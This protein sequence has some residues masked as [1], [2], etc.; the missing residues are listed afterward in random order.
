MSNAFDQIELN[1]RAP[2]GHRD[3]SNNHHGSSFNDFLRQ[4]GIL[5]EVNELAARQIIAWQMEEQA[6]NQNPES[7]PAEHQSREDGPC[8]EGKCIRH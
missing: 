6:T 1:T 2:I 5:D 4:E 3:M 7:S 8:T